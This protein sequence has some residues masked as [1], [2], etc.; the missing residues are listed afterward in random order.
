MIIEVI[1]MVVV[2]KYKKYIF[3]IK[4]LNIK[5]IY[6]MSNQ[7]DSKIIDKINKLNSQIYEK[8]I[9]IE[10]MLKNIYINR[11]N[12][13][14]YRKELSKTCPHDWRVDH[15]NSSYS[16]RTPRICIICQSSNF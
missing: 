1:I 10:N 3:Y 13:S 16:D 8:E 14:K 11:Q 15:D 2:N 6:K 5:N 12:I 4:N 9:E 7:I